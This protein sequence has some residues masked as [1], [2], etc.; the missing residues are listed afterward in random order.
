MI[1]TVHPSFLLRTKGAEDKQKKYCELVA[2]LKI[3][4]KLLKKAA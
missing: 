1:V 3:C 4:A 2:D